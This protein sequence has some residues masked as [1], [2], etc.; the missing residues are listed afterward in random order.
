MVTMVTMVAKRV[1]TIVQGHP[2]KS[3]RS[4]LGASIAAAAAAAAARG[5]FHKSSKMALELI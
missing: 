3:K 5:Q 4:I 2:P 1:I